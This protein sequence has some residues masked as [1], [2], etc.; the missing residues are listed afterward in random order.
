MKQGDIMAGNKSFG[1]HLKQLR[2]A[3]R[4]SQEQLAELVGLEYQ[5]ISRIETG[6]YFSS[7]E[8][9]QKIAK[10]LNITMKDLF[11]FSEDK[12]SKIQLLKF[13]TIDI[14]NFDTEDLNY[15]YKIICTC[16]EWK[17]R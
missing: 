14:K 8:N 13:I 7:F 10:A 9:L 12:P 3:R 15:I 16:K 6:I 17:N 5:T 1:R 11:D 2:E 4:L